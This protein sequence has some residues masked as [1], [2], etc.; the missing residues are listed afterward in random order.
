MESG[1][2]WKRSRREEK[3]RRLKGGREVSEVKGREVKFLI[4]PFPQREGGFGG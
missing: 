4:P 1:Q 2:N 3:G